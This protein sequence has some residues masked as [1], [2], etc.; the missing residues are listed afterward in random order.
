MEKKDRSLKTLISKKLESEGINFSDFYES[1]IKYQCKISYSCFMEMIHQKTEL[2][3]EVEKIL[4]EFANG[5]NDVAG[6]VKRVKQRFAYCPEGDGFLE[7]IDKLIESG[8]II[9]HSKRDDLISIHLPTSIIKVCG[10]KFDLRK[11]LEENSRF[12]QHDKCVR[13]IEAKSGENK[14]IRVSIFHKPLIQDKT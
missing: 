2:R 13:N 10:I 1:S 6:R 7:K 14:T 4:L 12:V 3:K 9:N 11:Q 8:L 5:R